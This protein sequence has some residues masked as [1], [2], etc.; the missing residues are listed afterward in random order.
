MSFN[1]AMYKR[2][3]LSVANAFRAH[4]AGEVAVEEYEKIVAEANLLKPAVVDRIVRE[5]II[6]G[7]K[8]RPIDA[9]QF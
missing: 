6:R 3:C 5:V 4:A 9:Y 1:I 8:F 2:Q 7:E